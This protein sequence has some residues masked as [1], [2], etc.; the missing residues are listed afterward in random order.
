LSAT[1]KKKP[2]NRL[3]GKCLRSCRQPQDALLLDCP[4]FTPRPF[5]I[6]QHRFE[7]Q[8]LFGGKKK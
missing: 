2:V 7:Q 3:C 6:A 1:D 8:E 4:R 5:K